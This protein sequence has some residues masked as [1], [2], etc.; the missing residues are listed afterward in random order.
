[1]IWGGLH[2][3]Y[4]VLERLVCNSPVSSLAVWKSA[5]SRFALSLLT[6]AL[7]CVTWVFFRAE[8][9][10][11]A[12]SICGAML[13]VPGALAIAESMVSGVSSET[14]GEPLW[15]GYGDY[16]TVFFLTAA[17]LGVHHLLRD[18]SLEEGF[19][20]LRWWLRSIVVAVM[21]C[22]IVQSMTGEDNAFIYFQ[23]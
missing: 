21:I 14:V 12:L 9:L 22:C 2:G 1:M 11:S 3:L 4:L 7:V 5:G 17:M 16:M 10:A 20:R 15:L 6:F 23:F 13:D 19:G 8:N 18:S